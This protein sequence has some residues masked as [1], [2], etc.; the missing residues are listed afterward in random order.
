MQR[1]AA[2]AG[3]SIH[4]Y[5]TADWR[6]F[7]HEY[8]LVP[9]AHYY[10]RPKGIDQV[11]AFLLVLQQLVMKDLQFLS[12]STLKFLEVSARSSHPS[13]LVT[14]TKAWLR[15]YPEHTDVWVDYGIGHGAC[16]WIEEIRRQEP[17]QL[18]VNEPVRFRMAQLAAFRVKLLSLDVSVDNPSMLCDVALKSLSSTQGVTMS[19]RK[20]VLRATHKES[21]IGHSLRSPALG[22]I[23]DYGAHANLLGAKWPSYKG[24]AQL[25]GKSP[26]G[27]VTVYVDPTLGVPALQNARDLMADADRVVKANDALFGT[28]GGPVEVIVFALFGKTDGTGGAD[29]GGCDYAT[30]AAI[31]VC[32]SFG[33]S[34]RVSALFEAELSECS[35]GGNLCGVSTGEALSRW[36]AA[37]T[38]N[39]ALGDF[40]TAPTWM[41]VGAPDFVTRTDPTDGNAISTGCGMAFLSWLQ[42]IGQPL[43]KV[44]HAM[45]S[46]GDK[47]T[48]AQLYNKLT[49]DSEANALPKFKAAL[50]A[51]PGGVTSDDPFKGGI[52]PKPPTPKP[53]TPKPPTPKP[54]TPQPPTPPTPPSTGSTGQAFAAWVPPP[55]PMY[56]T[57][58]P[59][60]PPPAAPPTVLGTAHPSLETVAK[61]LAGGMASSPA[62][63]L[64]AVVGLVVLG[65]VAVVGLADGKREVPPQQ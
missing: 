40:A 48:L 33:N 63:G 36:C 55:Y 39:N 43:N 56:P 38:S 60:P 28:T 35:M 49:S 30:G 29:H 14:A 16:V 6:P 34:A 26:S 47:G 46:L 2:F 42:S 20:V 12:Y 5:R 52:P 3:R 61:S 17:T 24:T 31:E 44:S 8:D 62:L 10:L 64:V 37:V 13:F 1:M 4:L 25:V 41:H 57:Y 7:L 21:K 51:L 22:P 27:R 23:T 11:D 53:P 32:A 59:L 58:P 18:G 50:A 45:V 65:V 15:S 54:P 19:K 9:P